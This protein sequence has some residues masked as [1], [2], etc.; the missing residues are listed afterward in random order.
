VQ[1]QATFRHGK[2]QT[3]NLTGL[4]DDELLSRRH[5]AFLRVARTQGSRMLEASA[6]DDIEQIITTRSPW[7]IASSTA[8]HASG[9]PS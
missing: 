4:A 3:K 2:S 5:Q 7:A 1:A 9:N 6:Y 8:K